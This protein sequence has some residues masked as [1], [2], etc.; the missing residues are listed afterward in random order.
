MTAA[1]YGVVVTAQAK[2]RLS[3]FV[4]LSIHHPRPGREPDLIAS[5]H[6]FGAAAG[7]PG[8]REAHTF[9]DDA[10]RTLAGLAIWDD[11]ASWRAGVEAMRAAV[12]DDPFEEWEERRP[13][14]LH[15]A[16]V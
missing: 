4:H 1:K 2:R 16:E 6:R 9:R 3:V 7:Q 15:L 12:A 5:M 14:V 8:F 10:R 13:E 11:E